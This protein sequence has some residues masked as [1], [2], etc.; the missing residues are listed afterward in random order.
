MIRNV[1]ALERW[2]GAG[3]YD[4]LGHRPPYLEGGRVLDFFEEY[5]NRGVLI[6]FCGGPP[7]YVDDSKRTV[8]VETI[9]FVEDEDEGRR[10]ATRRARHH[11]G[12]GGEITE[13]ERRARRRARERRG[14]IGKRGRRVG[15]VG[16]VGG[17]RFEP[18]YDLDELL[19]MEGT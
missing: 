2:R 9:G 10:A 15:T 5:D 16:D 3:E 13:S 6:P 14:G 11:L 7:V 19:A 18:V 8:L 12:L 4:L 1:A 17:G